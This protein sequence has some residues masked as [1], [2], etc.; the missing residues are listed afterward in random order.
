MNNLL[1]EKNL[2]LRVGAAALLIGGFALAL[3]HVETGTRTT[4]SPQAA[5]QA[6]QQKIEHCRDV[7]GTIERLHCWERAADKTLARYSFATINV[8]LEHAPFDCHDFMHYVARKAYADFDSLSELYDQATYACFGAAYHGGVE[9]FLESEGLA[10]APPQRI[11][12]TI[13][14]VCEEAELT[15]TRNIR[16]QCYHGLGHAL[17]VISDGDLPASLEFCSSLRTDNRALDLT[18][19]GG[20]FMENLPN[21]QTNPHVPRYIRDDDPLFPCNTIPE[22]FKETCY[23]FQTSHF[24]DLAGG[25]V[26]KKIELCLRVPSAY[27]DT[28][29]TH[30]GTGLLGKH[31][32]LEAVAAV[33]GR[34]PK[35]AFRQDCSRGVV[36]SYIDRFA[37]VPN[38][39]RDMFAYCDRVPTADVTACHQQIDQTLT[40]L[41]AGDTQARTR[42]CADV[43]AKH[44][45]LCMH[46]NQ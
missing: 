12:D 24:D 7:V 11:I 21:S 32:D 5:Q 29:I 10:G 23:G 17:M 15:D 40:S 28:C 43:P 9:G 25:D 20:V 36:L 4:D 13:R 42:F 34:M 2:V 33:C 35:T 14:R 26:E 3:A 31:T 1:S 46:G 27:Q 41:F 18:C 6:V 38:K 22:R 16:N 30:I 45:L 39:L 19:A 8:G 37:G 44:H